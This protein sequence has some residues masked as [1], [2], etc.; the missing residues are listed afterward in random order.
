[1]LKYLSHTSQ[2]ISK[3]SYSR[4]PQDYETGIKPAS[5]RLESHSSSSSVHSNYPG[6]A[7]STP[8]HSTASNSLQKEI[9]STNCNVKEFFK[10]DYSQPRRKYSSTKSVEESFNKKENENGR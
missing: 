5:H 3:V 7:V 1:M 4:N 9:R 6:S 10:L 8:K 2:P